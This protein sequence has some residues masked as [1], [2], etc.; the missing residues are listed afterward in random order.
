MKALVRLLFALTVALFVGA[1]WAT[2]GEAHSGHEP[3]AATQKVEPAHDR[4]SVNAESATVTRSA[5]ETSCASGDASSDG[6]VCCGHACHAAA[7]LEVMALPAVASA[8]ATAPEALEP[9]AHGGPDAHLMRP[10]R[11][12]GPSAG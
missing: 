6:A 11:P 4:V 10:P 8:R 1:L 2:P 12:V 3:T 7:P 9:A 5:D